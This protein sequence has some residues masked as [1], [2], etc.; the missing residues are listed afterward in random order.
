MQVKYCPTDDVDA[1]YMT[2]PLVGANSSSTEIASWMQDDTH[3]CPAG[4]CWIISLYQVFK[5]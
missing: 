1:N 4:G 5:K 3:G 2:K